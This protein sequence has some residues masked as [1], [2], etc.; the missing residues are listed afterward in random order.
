MLATQACF[1]A[2]LQISTT[3]SFFQKEYVVWDWLHL[4][5]FTGLCLSE[6]TQSN[7]WR[8]QRFHVVPSSDDTGV[9]AGQPLAFIHDDF[10]FY[11]GSDCLVPHSTLYSRHS[12]K[13]VSMVHIRFRYD[14]SAISWYKNFLPPPTPF[15]F[16]LTQ[17]SVSFTA[18]LSLVLPPMN[19]QAFITRLLFSR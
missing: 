12:K 16:L 9:W 1:L 14:K 19:R 13:Q 7:L 3:R 8:G 4:G 10:M 11:E 18:L 5:I 6:Y 17:Q 15:W 2:Q